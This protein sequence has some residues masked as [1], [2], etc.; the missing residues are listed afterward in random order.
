MSEHDIPSRPVVVGVD[1]RPGSRAALRYALAEARR[2]GSPVRL[3]HV[4]PNYVPVPPIRPAVPPAL[5]AT[6]REILRLAGTEARRLAPETEVTTLLASGTRADCLV[7]VAAD[8]RLLVVG[9]EQRSLVTR[10]WTGSTGT[11]V[12]ARAGCPVVSVPAG[13]EPGRS[14]G[15]VVAA[16][17][18][19]DHSQELLAHAFAAAAERGGELVVL[20]AWRLPGVY[21]D[22]IEDRAGTEEWRAHAL[23]VIEPLLKDLG[24]AHPEV[25]VRVE[26]IHDQPAHALVHASEAADLLVLVRRP[27]PHPAAWSLGV[28]ARAVLRDA[29]CPVEVV[30][31]VS[32]LPPSVP[33]LVLE[34]A[35]ALQK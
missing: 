12:S 20:H 13:W 25:S 10:V 35:G 24:I 3:V 33:G 8:A 21:A 15:P 9:H 7:E 26:V 27:H 14:R 32:A 19:T 28:T 29:H 1:G 31:T 11:G 22:I 6:G 2:L 23:T 16:F 18:T 5:T 34:D 4:S 17:K 30:P